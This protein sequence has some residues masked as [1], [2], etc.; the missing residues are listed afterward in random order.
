MAID[1][2]LLRILGMRVL[3]GGVRLPD[4]EQRV[5]D[6]CAIAV[7]DTALD[8]DRLALG[9]AAIGEVGPGGVLEAETEEGPHRLRG[10]GYPL[11]RAF[12][13]GVAARPRSTMSKR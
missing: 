1:L 5:R 2:L 4:F 13:T 3:A 9:F 12:S 11:H 6:R 10:R 7:G 8:A